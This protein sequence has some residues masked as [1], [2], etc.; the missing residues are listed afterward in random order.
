MVHRTNAE[1]LKLIKQWEAFI[2]FACDDVDSAKN[3]RRIVAGD[4]LQPRCRRSVEPH[5]RTQNCEAERR[6]NRRR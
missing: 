4:R 6:Q 3:R 5:R 2:P 1:G